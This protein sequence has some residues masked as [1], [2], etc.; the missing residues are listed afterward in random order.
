MKKLRLVK[1]VVQPVFVL[2]DGKTLTEME[3]PAI[4]I[5]PDE[6]PA[7]SGERFPRETAEWE[8][9]LNAPP[10]RAER[11]RQTKEKTTKGT[12]DA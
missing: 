2:D 5:P 3:H 7:Y 8:R 6:W 12:A 4:V 10:S 11:R 9:R 1:V